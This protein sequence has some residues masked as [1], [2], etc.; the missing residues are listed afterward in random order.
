MITFQ[1]RVYLGDYISK[2]GLFGAYMDVFKGK[3]R[4]IGSAVAKV[5]FGTKALGRRNREVIGG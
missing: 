2:K 4:D 3:K 1:K 5:D